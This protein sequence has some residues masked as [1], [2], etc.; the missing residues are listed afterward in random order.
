MVLHARHVAHVIEAAAQALA[1]RPAAQEAFRSH[2]EE[3]R[4]HDA[5]AR[6]D[7]EALGES[8]AWEPTPAFLALEGYTRNLARERPLGVLGFLVMAEGLAARFGARW[9]RVLGWLGFGAESTRF[10][11]LHVG[12]DAEHFPKLRRLC[13][14]HAESRADQVAILQ[15]IRVTSD[16]MARA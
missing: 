12:V 7:L 16:L 13:L 3:E 8:E 11:S 14:E 9:L 15:A 4:G 10:L 1:G 2:G 5:L 6:A